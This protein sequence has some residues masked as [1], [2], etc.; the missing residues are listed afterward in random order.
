MTWQGVDPSKPGDR[1]RAGRWHARAWCRIV[2]HYWYSIT[3]RGSSRWDCGRCK[4]AIICPED[5]R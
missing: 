2:G 3:Y 1:V 4:K 5:R